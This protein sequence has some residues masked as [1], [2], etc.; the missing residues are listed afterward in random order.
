M[1]VV[2]E[3]CVCFSVTA[4]EVAYTEWQT[5]V[6]IVFKTAELSILNFVGNVKHFF[7]VALPEYGAWLARNWVN[8]FIDLGNAIFTIWQNMVQKLGNVIFE[9]WMFVE[10][11]FEGGLARLG[12]RISNASQGSLLEGFEAQTE[13]LPEI[14]ARKLTSREKQLADEIGALG[15][16]LGNAFNDKF[17]ARIAALNAPVD[18]DAN[19]G[20][21]GSGL[22]QAGGASGQLTAV[23]GRL[24]TRGPGEDPLNKIEQNTKRTADGIE[25]MHKDM[26]LKDSPN[27]I[28]QFEE[29]K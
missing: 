17:Q 11:G 23:Q 6:Q 3:Y 9:F 18:F 29:V 7:T 12:E 21:G 27:A 22:S 24:L 15:N 19:F 13:A 5:V 8:L 25:K 14:M 4:V 1:L 2:F 26:V 20:T 16:H 10:S 28:V